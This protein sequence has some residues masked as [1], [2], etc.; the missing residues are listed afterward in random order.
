MGLR[1]PERRNRERPTCKL[2]NNNN[3]CCCSD[4]H[5]DGRI[6]DNYFDNSD[7]RADNYSTDN[8]GAD[9]HGA[10]NHGADNYHCSS[11]GHVAAGCWCTGVS[12]VDF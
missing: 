10:D 12:I 6:D 5:Y 2:D 1:K 9:N 11:V 3:Y 7:R 8:H 4:H